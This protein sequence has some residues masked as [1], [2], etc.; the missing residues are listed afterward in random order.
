VLCSLTGSAG[1]IVCTIEK[2]NTLINT[3]LEEGQLDQ[4]GRR[5]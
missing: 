4:V 2:A 3:L 5:G 1:V